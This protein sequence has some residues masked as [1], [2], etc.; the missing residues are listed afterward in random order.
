MDPFSRP[1]SKNATNGILLVLR[2]PRGEDAGGEGEKGKGVMTMAGFGDGRR[3]LHGG[4][5]Y[6]PVWWMRGLSWH[7]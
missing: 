6:G 7:Q 1:N 3:P 4:E 2:Y 5:M